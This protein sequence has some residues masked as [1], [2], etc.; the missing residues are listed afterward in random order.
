MEK[1]KEQLQKIEGAKTNSD[2]KRYLTNYVVE[3]FP[4]VF[5][6]KPF[7]GRLYGEIKRHHRYLT[8]FTAT[9]GA[10]GDKER[11]LTAVELLSTQ[12]MLMFLLALLYDVQAPTNDGSCTTHHSADSCYQRRS[13]FDDSQAYCVW[14]TPGT[15]TADYYCEY[16]QPEFSLQI[17]IYISVIVALLTALIQFPLDACMDLLSAPI[18]DDLKLA[19]EETAMNKMG[20]R[21]SNVARRVSLVASNLT[22]AAQNKLSSTRKSLVGTLARKIPESTEVAHSLASVSMQLIVESTQRSLRE[23]ELNQIRQFRQSGGRY[24]VTDNAYESDES[25]SSDS[26]SDVE[27]GDE[28]N[29]GQPS[30]KRL[31]TRPSQRAV[32]KEERIDPNAA[33]LTASVVDASMLRLTAEISCQ[34]RL[35]VEDDRDLFDSQWGLDPTGEFCQGEHSRLPFLFK[36]KPGA[37]QLIRGEL[38]FVKSETAKKCDKLRV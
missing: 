38:E 33:S 29:L 2:V 19:E 7:F 18:A 37:Q 34:R 17:V 15:N 32:V 35:L 10:T 9:E 25:S 36:G 6:N 5:S 26:H 13:P 21:M 23:R 24:Q 22:T 4:S 12:T 1:I 11:I 27:T 14:Q 8:L 30:S 31:H 20:R 16:A 28:E 3:I